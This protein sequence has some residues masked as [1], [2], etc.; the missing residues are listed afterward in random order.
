MQGEGG[1]IGTEEKDILIPA[2][3]EL[4]KKKINVSMPLSADTAFSKKL[5]KETD[6]YLGMYHDQV[7]P[8]N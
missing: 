6:A 3:K 8:C 1:K 4:K 5:L 2:V 7:L